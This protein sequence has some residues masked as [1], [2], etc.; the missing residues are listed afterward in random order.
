VFLR[1]PAQ[2]NLVDPQSL[3]SYSYSDDSPI[4]R[5]DPSGQSLTTGLQGA[6]SPF[7]YAYHHPFQSAGF[8]LVGAGVAAVAP[9]AAA[10]GGVALGGYAIGSAIGH[11][12]YAPN[13]DTRDYYLGQG[14]TFAGLT[15]FGFRGAGS[16]ESSA[17]ENVLPDSALCVRGGLCTPESFERGND[18]PL[19]NGNLTDVSVNSAP[20]LTAQQLAEYGIPHNQMGVTTVGEIRQAG[21]NVVSS[22]MPGNP[23]HATLSGITPAQASSLMAI[24]QNLSNTLS[25]LGNSL[26]K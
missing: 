14:L 19:L 9:A 8:I 26:K 11:A 23:Y 10:I 6:A 20:G 18:G 7:V 15:A 5:S 16:T 17:G 1:N 22:P 13:A 25:T 2:Q 3:N 24:L 21:G 4:V 12:I